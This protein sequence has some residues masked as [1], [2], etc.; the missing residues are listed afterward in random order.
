MLTI[1]PSRL[2]SVSVEQWTRA[3]VQPNANLLIYQRI[4]TFPDVTALEDSSV[5]TSIK[6]KP[7][8]QILAGFQLNLYNILKDKLNPTD[9]LTYSPPQL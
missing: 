2:V 4:N 5:T 8:A 7:I 1:E 3:A 6:E 9:L